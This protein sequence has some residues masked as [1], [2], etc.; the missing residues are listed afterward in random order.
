MIL[1]FLRASSRT[2][3]HLIAGNHLPVD[4]KVEIAHWL[5]LPF[6]RTSFGGS[7]YFNGYHGF[8]SRTMGRWLIDRPHTGLDAVGQNDIF[9]KI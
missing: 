1:P 7:L 4:E 3:D 6:E 8:G 9:N 2:G 5:A